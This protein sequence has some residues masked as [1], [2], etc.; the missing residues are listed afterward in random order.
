MNILL[1]YP[2]YPDTYWSFKHVLKFVSKKATFP[3]LGLLTVAALLPQEW[4]KKLVDLNVTEL[5]DEQIAWADM[6]FLSAMIVQT[7]SAREVIR[8]CKAA[9]KTIVAGGPAATT[10]HEKLAGVDHFVLNEA[11]ITLPRFLA[12]WK[13]GRP[14]AIYESNERPDITR[15]PVP[16]WSLINLKDYVTMP[17]QYSRGCPFDCEFCDI[18]V[19]YGR[20]PR[21]KNPEQMIREMQALREAGWKGDVFIVDD[22][23][24]G[25]KSRVKKMLPILSRWQKIPIHVYH[26]SK[27]QSGRR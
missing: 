10:G 27:H 19:M 17:V 3:P 1:I 23:F 18:I 15:T 4:D 9:G 5:K 14:K 21:T 16:L 20:T 2:K 12:D 8:R 7:D 24:I 26:R 25:N 11:E 22:N 6:V 13:E